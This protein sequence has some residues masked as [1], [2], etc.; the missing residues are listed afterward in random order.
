MAIHI[1][2]MLLPCLPDGARLGRKQMGLQTGSRDGLT[3]CD[4][5]LRPEKYSVGLKGC[6]TRIKVARA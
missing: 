3:W 4:N 5:L 1:K 2:V 6:M